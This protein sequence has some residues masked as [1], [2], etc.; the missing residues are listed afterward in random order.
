MKA[1]L[2]SSEGRLRHAV[3][4]ELSSPEV[5]GRSG[6]YRFTAGIPLDVEPGLYVIHVEAR[7]NSDGSTTVSRDVQ[8]RVK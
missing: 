2:R 7:G 4:E 1:L 8:I 6:S 5:Q 3:E